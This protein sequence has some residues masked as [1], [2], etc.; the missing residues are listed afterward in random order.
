MLG[1]DGQH[2]DHQL[3]GVRIVRS[4]EIDA[5]FHEAGDEMDVSGQTIEFR[6]DQ[7]C[8]GLLSS[9]DGSRKLAAPPLAIRRNPVV[10]DSCVEKA[11]LSVELTS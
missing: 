6:N 3:I 10:S 2:V 1:K 4:D 8:L 7:G 5:T 11:G 9:C